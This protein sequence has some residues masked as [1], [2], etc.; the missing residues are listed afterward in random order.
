MKKSREL[1]FLIAAILISPVF[2]AFLGGLAADVGLLFAMDFQSWIYSLPALLKSNAVTAVFGIFISL[3]VVLIYGVPVY[4]LLR[5]LKLQNI[6][7]YGLFGLLPTSI[8]TLVS[9]INQEAGLVAYAYSFS[10][11]AMRGLFV[12]CV[13]WFIAVYMPTRSSTINEGLTDA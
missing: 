4:F 12:A 6:W 10:Q 1:A 13:F 2:G 3:P 9:W 5:K 8:G 11:G 7:M